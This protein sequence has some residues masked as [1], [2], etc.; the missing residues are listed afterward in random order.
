MHNSLPSATD[1]Y[2]IPSSLSD[3]CR[4]YLSSEDTCIIPPMTIHDVGKCIS[5]MSNKKSAG[6]DNVSSFLLK[7]SLPYIVEPLTYVYNRCI[8]TNIFPHALKVAKVIPIPKNKDTSDMN[9]FRPIS[10][11]PILSKPIE[12]H[13]QKHVTHFI[14][15]KSL[16]FQYQSGFRQNHSCHTALIRLCDKWLTAINNNNISGAVFLDLRKAFDL[17][18]HSIL[19]KK[20]ELYL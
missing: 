18:D 13:I 20:F 4:Q 1:N 2:A 15:R 6:V 16:L 7:L 3:P 8:E 11:L 5:E 14:E 9:N 19:V 10:L 12:K 17:V